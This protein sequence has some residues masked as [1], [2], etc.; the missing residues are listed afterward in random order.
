L[1][2]VHIKPA[3]DI[4]EGMKFIFTGWRDSVYAVEWH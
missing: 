3:R 1:V 2:K 4:V